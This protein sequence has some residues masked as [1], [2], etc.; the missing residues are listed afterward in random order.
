MLA[1]R[2]LIITDMAIASDRGL[3]LFGVCVCMWRWSGSNLISA[4]ICTSPSKTT[5]LQIVYIEL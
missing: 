5:I 2:N 1:T 4:A 3:R